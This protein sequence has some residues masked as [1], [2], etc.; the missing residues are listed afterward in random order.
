MYQVTHTALHHNGTEYPVGSEVAGELFTAE[1]LH[2]LLAAGILKEVPP[3][4]KRTRKAE[5]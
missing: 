1:Q 2:S 5:V 4:P 3:P